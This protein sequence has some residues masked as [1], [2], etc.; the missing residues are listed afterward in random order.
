MQQPRPIGVEDYAPFV[1]AETVARIRAKASPLAGRRIAH[2]NA[3]Y[4]GG[5]A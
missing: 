1:G 3:T 5:G 2:I 4:H